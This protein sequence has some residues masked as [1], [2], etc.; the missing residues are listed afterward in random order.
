MCS[1]QAGEPETERAGQW[2]S[3]GR[4]ERAAKPE[5]GADERGETQNQGGN[6]HESAGVHFFPPL[7]QVTSL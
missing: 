1:G 5:G 2:R 4:T 3:P 7:C 6:D